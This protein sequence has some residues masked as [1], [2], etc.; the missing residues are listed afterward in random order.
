M[1]RRS[2]IEAASEPVLGFTGFYRTRLEARMVS[3]QLNNRA[4]TSTPSAQLRAGG[5]AQSR[6]ASQP[7]PPEALRL[8]CIQLAARPPHEPHTDQGSV[9]DECL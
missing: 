8:D 2:A 1:T 5:L 9:D 3:M 4:A 6:S 7:A